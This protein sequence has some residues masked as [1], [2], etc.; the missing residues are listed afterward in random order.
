MMKLS[1]T[2]GLVAAVLLISAGSA[3][4]D[5]YHYDL[6]HSQ[7]N[8]QYKN[9][10]QHRYQHHQNGGNRVVVT[11]EVTEN[12]VIIHKTITES[13]GVT[14]TIDKA[15]EKGPHGHVDI[16]KKRNGRVIEQHHSR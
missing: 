12:G 10:N 7:S 1:L 14:Y 9:N 15:I 13:N 8:S 5:Q 11:K 6:H 3:M 2:S 4:A 16:E